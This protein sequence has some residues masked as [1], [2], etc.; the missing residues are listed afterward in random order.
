MSLYDTN[1]KRHMDSKIIH[2]FQLNIW[3]IL[4]IF[5]FKRKL[6]VRV[7]LEG[8]ALNTRTC[9]TGK[10]TEQSKHSLFLA[11]TAEQVKKK[12]VPLSRL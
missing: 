3:K 10:F 4:Q 12:E 2:T 11:E 8:I 9:V 6:F 7:T 5:P 1:T